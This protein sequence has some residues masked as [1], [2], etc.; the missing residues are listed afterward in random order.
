[1]HFTAVPYNGEPAM[2]LALA[3]GQVDFV[4]TTLGGGMS[5][6]RGGKLRVLGML[7][8]ARFDLLPEVPTMAEQGVPGVE[9]S[10]VPCIVAPAGT[11][12]ET[13]D[14]MNRVVNQVLGMPQVRQRMHNLL[15]TQAGGTP[16]DLKRL[17]K[18][19]GERWIPIIQ[20]LGIHEE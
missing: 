2:M 10:G 8:A 12:R 4:I 13:L 1:V 14:R 15:M 7:D 3:G 6:I 11:P 20:R 19:E 9:A 5:L 18:A 17:M 16:E